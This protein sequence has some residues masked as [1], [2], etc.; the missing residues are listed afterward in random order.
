M[1]RERA[2]SFDEALAVFT[3]LWVEASALRADFPGP[4]QDDLEADLA[5]AR[6]VNHD[7]AP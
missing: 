1:A 4:W 5:V 2:R 6:M 3:A 7:E